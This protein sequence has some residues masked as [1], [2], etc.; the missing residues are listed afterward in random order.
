[1]RV[2]AIRV[3]RDLWSLLEKEAALVGVSVSQYIREAA[4]AR[5]SGAAAVRGEDPTALLG[6][7]A[8]DPD[9]SERGDGAVAVGPARPEH[10][11]GDA[12]DAAPPDPPESDRDRYQRARETA[13]TTR[14]ESQAVRAQGEQILR[15]FPRQDPDEDA[16]SQ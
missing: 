4:L 3:G 13:Q 5:A 6:R 15:R 8:V 7:A 14:L 9:L 1:M 12:A 16:P 2:T 11:G 10:P